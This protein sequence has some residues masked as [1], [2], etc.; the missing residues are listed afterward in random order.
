MTFSFILR[1]NGQSFFYLKFYKSRV[2]KKLSHSSDSFFVYSAFQSPKAGT[3]ISGRMVSAV[4]LTNKICH[5][6]GG[7]FGSSD[8]GF[9]P[10]F[11]AF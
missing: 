8:S 1:K 10:R 11:D 2:Y 5:D 3:R 7:C 4:S 6:L 9:F